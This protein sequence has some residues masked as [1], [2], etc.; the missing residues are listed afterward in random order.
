MLSCPTISEAFGADDDTLR[1][2][3]SDSSSDAMQWQT[4]EVYD[5]EGIATTMYV[6][7]VYSQ[8]LRKLEMST[9]TCTPT[10]HFPP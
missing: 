5:A 3:L 8:L 2:V 10:L 7:Y 1:R 4:L 6:L 9:S